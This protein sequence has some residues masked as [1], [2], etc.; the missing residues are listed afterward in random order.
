M[1]K[2][3]KV[4]YWG[5]TGLL[6]GMMAASAVMYVFNYSQVSTVFVALG[7]PTYLIYPLAVAKLLGVTAILTKKSRLLKDLAYAGFLYDFLLA[8]AAHLNA[9]DGEYIPAFAALV[10]LIVSFIYDRKLFSES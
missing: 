2:R 10:L 8:A 3:D 5:S 1:M 4:I 6:C 9:G 7:Y